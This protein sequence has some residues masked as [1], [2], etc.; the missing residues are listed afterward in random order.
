MNTF[1]DALGAYWD[2]AYAEGSRGAAHDDEEGTAQQALA[3]VMQAHELEVEAEIE[4]LK[5]ALNEMRADRDSWQEQA[6]QRV[7]D[8]VDFLARA[9]R[10]ED[11]RDALRLDLAL[12]DDGNGP[13]WCGDCGS[14]MQA[15]RPGKH[16]CTACEV[17]E[18]LRSKLDEPP[19][20]AHEAA[21][22]A[23]QRQL[24]R[25]MSR[26]SEDHYCAGW[27]AGNEYRLWHAITDLG[28]GNRCGRGSL[29][30]KDAEALRQLAARID[31]WIYWDDGDLGPKS[32]PTRSGPRFMPKKD[33]A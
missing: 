12:S 6:N 32:K 28:E 16:Q 8:A 9:E 30:P 21:L 14:L 18:G 33:P 13:A 2:A 27:I 10:A 11:E 25:L 24:Y 1:T 29:R 20:D 26:I 15:V 3:S 4:N 22:T 31:G 19:Y 7:T 5:A 23:D 17:S